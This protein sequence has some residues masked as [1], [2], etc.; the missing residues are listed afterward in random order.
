M[1]AKKNNEG[2]GIFKARFVAKGY[3]QIPQ[4]QFTDTFSPTARLTSIRLL[5]NIAANENM[6]VHSMDF[7]SAY[8]NAEVDC[9]I[10]LEQPK[11]FIIKNDNNEDLVLKLKKSLFSAQ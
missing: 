8:L 1:Y 6:V 7:K 9:E 5:M 11:G 2:E 10:F 4:A 3:A